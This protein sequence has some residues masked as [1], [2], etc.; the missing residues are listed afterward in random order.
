MDS[1]LAFHSVTDG[2]WL[3]SLIT[4]LAR[5]F[6]FGCLQDLIRYYAGLRFEKPLC[7][8][9]VD[10]GDRTFYDVMWPVL[11]KHGVPATVF[12]SPQACSQ[13]KNFWFQEIRA[14]RPELLRTAAARVLGVGPA[15][16]APFR[17]ESIF[18]ALSV[19]RMA[20]V[21]DACQRAEGRPTPECDNMSV[22]ELREICG[23]GLVT[24]GGHTMN[25]PILRNEHD[26]SC[27]FEITESVQQ[28]TA[29]VDRPVSTFAYPN[30][31]YGLDFGEREQQVLRACGVRMAF[32]MHAGRLTA[33]DN[34]LQIPRIA[35]S[36]REPLN[37][38]TLKLT[39]GSIWGRVKKLVHAGEEAERH[40]LG[41][42]LGR[43]QPA[44]A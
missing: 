27:A 14:F 25:H 38:I 10:D 19:S 2:A 24:L 42:V 16:L 43:Q 5:K 20:E 15:V 26:R 30:G 34:P 9:T 22:A 23:T 12:V 28:L 36:D 13:R 41:C 31:I 40:R 8:I 39:A 7:L 11:R 32:T 17:V 3:E 18:K 1:V 29:L 4:S 21:I 44:T 37:R 33:G 6:A 35:I